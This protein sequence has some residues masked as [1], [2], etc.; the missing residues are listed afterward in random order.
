[1]TRKAW[2][3]GLKPPQQELVVWLVISQK[4]EK[5]EKLRLET[6]SKGTYTT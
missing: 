3:W 2:Q 5:Q 4:I 1:M 6:E